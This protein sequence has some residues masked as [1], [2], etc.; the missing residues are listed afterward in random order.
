MKK[1][2]PYILYSLVILAAAGLLAYQG[3][4]TKELTS[5]NLTRGLLIIA[6]ALVGMFR[7]KR[8]QKVSNKKV[9]YQK[10][11]P[12]FV[13]GAFAEEPKL[14]KKLREEHIDRLAK[15][16]C[17]SSSGVVFLDIV[18]NLERVSDHADN[19]A[20]YVLENN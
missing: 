1:A 5:S 12:E 17:N 8:R 15:G 2:L 3:L 10:A 13:T 20:G 14:E 16:L 19:I 4:V 9:V 7:P 18:S 11:F 6:A